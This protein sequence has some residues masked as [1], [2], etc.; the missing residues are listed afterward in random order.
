[1]A[2]KAA[3]I[4]AEPPPLPTGPFRTIIADPPWYYARDDD[5]SH[6]GACPYPTMTV[7]EIC[8][9]PIAELAAEDAILWLW[10][11]NPNLRHAF[12]VID[13]WGFEERTILTWV[14]PHFG[15]GHW[16]RGQT[17]HCIMAIRG[18]PTITLSN[19]A[20]VLHAPAPERRHS[21]KPDEF[22][23]LVESLCPGSK[24]ELFCRQPRP[25]WSSW[26]DEVV[27]AAA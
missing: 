24:I 26:G 3:A 27:G 23:Q 21:R 17:E 18:R 4:A 5:A 25:G 20:T 12:T 2:Q 15:C 10:A 16:L 6:R 8:A 19:Q 1:V 7:P 13:S 11:T 22:Y 14:K 9:M